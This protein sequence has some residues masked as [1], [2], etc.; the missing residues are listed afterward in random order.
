[1][2]RRAM[3]TGRIKFIPPFWREG[4]GSYQ[5]ASCTMIR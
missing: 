3:I 5:L 2:C 1:M 4:L